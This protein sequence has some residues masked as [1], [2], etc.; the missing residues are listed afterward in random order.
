[1]AELDSENQWLQ[2]ENRRLQEAIKQ[3]TI[4]T[5]ALYNYE[6]FHGLDH[7]T[8]TPELVSS[9]AEGIEGWAAGGG[10]KEGEVDL[11]ELQPVAPP[12]R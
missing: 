9:T 11:S 3:D 7:G 6:T 1:M 4:V 12:K 2:Q 5:V 8:A 10:K